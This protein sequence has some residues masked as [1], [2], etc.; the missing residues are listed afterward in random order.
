VAELYKPN[1]KFNLLLPKAG[2]KG[3]L[4]QLSN[5][6]LIKTNASLWSYLC[7]RE[8]TVCMDVNMNVCICKCTYVR[9]YICMYVCMHARMHACMYVCMY[10]CICTY[11]YVRTHKYIQILRTYVFVCTFIFIHV[12]AVLFVCNCTIG[13]V[14]NLPN[15]DLSEQLVT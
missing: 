4:D 2:E 5:Y 15:S 14:P 1:T 3:I 11:K 10:V 8:C 7:G 13:Q 9:M 12:C 6:W